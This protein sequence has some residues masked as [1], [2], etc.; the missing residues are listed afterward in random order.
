MEKYFRHNH[1]YRSDTEEKEGPDSKEDDNGCDNWD[2]H[3]H[4]DKEDGPD[5][6]EEDGMRKGLTPSRSMEQTARRSEMGLT[7]M[8]STSTRMGTTMWGRT[9]P[10][11]RTGTTT[12]TRRKGTTTKTRSVG[13]TMRTRRMGPTTKMRRTGPKLR[14]GTMGPT[15]RRRVR[16]M[17]PT[18][19][20]GV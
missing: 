15:L 8:T 17:G 13:P 1:E 12:N 5:H 4:K 6:N 10:T 19:R 2:S 18:M 3:A 16:I 11:T 9:R 14:K 7:T 20:I